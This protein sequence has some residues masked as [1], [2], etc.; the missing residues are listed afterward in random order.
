MKKLISLLGALP[1]EAKWSEYAATLVTAFRALGGRNDAVIG[2]IQALGELEAF[3]PRVS[4][5]TFA[6]Y[7]QKSLEA[8]ADQSE[9]FEGGGVFVGDVMSARGLSWPLV[10][11]LGLVEKSF[12]RPVRED[13]LL[14]DEERARIS[15]ELPR[16]LDGHDEERLLFSL[17]TAAAREKLVL[18]Y[19]RL[20]PA[21][22]RPRLASFLLLE[23]AGAASF[24][25]LEKRAMRSR[26]SPVRETDEPLNER[27]LDL[28]ALQ[29]LADQL[30]LPAARVAVA[31]RWRGQCRYAL[32][33]ARAHAL[34]W[35]VGER[36]RAETLAGAVRP[37]ETRHQRHV[38]GGFLRLPVLLFPEA[39]ARHRAVGGTR[40][41]AFDRR[42]GSGFALSRDPGG[43]L[44]ITRPRHRAPSPKNISTSSSGAA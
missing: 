21:T 29:S 11:V 35:A 22:S 40:G 32:A 6:D 25:A 26:L 38:A 20:E 10:I 33:R 3:Q 44:S 41:R 2:C 42:A 12:P 34:R 14:T 30:A 4:F 27:E 13:P 43:L 19:P 9:K 7:C 39:R 16:K 23:Y 15:A 31:G 37:G 28:A 8:A 36:R 18:S 24:Q 1:G 5:D 17:A